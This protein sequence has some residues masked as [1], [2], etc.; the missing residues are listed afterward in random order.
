MIS[1]PDAIRQLPFADGTRRLVQLVVGFRLRLACLAGQ[2]FNLALQVLDAVCQSALALG[3][4]P[5]TLLAFRGTCL[6]AIFRQLVDAC[7]D[8][9]L[10]I[11]DRA[12]FLDCL[13]HLLAK[14]VF[15]ALCQGAHRILELLQGTDPLRSGLLAAAL[16]IFQG[17]FH[18]LDCLLQLVAR[19]VE[20]L[21]ASLPRKAL[22]LSLQL[23]RFVQKLLLVLAGSSR[24]SL[25]ALAYKAV[26]FVELLLA[27]R[28]LLE[29]FRSLVDLLVASLLFAALH[30]FILVLE[31]VHLK[32]EEVGQVLG[33]RL[34][35]RSAPAAGLILER[36]LDFPEKTLGT[37]KLLQSLLFL[38]QGFH[39]LFRAQVGRGLPHLI[40]GILHVFAQ[41]CEFLA[42]IEGAPPHQPVHQALSLCLQ[43]TFDQSEGLQVLLIL[44]RIQ[45]VLVA[46]ELEGCAD[47]LLLLLDELLLAALAAVPRLGALSPALLALCVFLFERPHLDEVDI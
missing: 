2:I 29:A 17:F 24:G 1:A 45:T 22:K 12:G 15:L 28:E 47:D 5:D 23:L 32:L 9:T 20:I 38:W 30:G 40:R 8:A 4:I 43:F 21:G 41:L 18:L 31:L 34:R 7:A 39:G 44:L 10:L 13:I 46:D 33:S 37:Q 27:L 35:L 42:H 19:P 25:R 26:A 16:L 6:L 36:N 11:Q 3:N 14:V